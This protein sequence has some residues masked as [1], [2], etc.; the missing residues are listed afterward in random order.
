[1]NP[2]L[3]LGYSCTSMGSDIG[4]CL[5]FTMGDES[6]SCA[7]SLHPRGSANPVEV[8]QGLPRYVIID[9][10]GNTIDIQAP[11]RNVSRDQKVHL[12][13]PKTLCHSIPLGLSQVAVEGTGIVSAS[14]QLP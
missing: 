6:D 10:V 9:D 11:S 13:F 3:Q 14:L 8:G 2:C 1:M 7:L 4:K 12:I 5:F